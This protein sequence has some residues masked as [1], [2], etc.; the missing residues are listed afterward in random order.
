[1]ATV[2]LARTVAGP[3]DGFPVLL[4]H[5]S[6]TDR[7]VWAPQIAELA[8]AGYR[9]IAADLRGHGESPLGE[10][11]STPETMA[12]DVFALLDELGIARFVVGGFSYGGWVAMEILRQS[13][14]RV[15]GL[16]LISTGAQADTAKEKA[17]R[18]T[19]AQ[20]IRRD[21]LNPDGYRERVLTPETLRTRPDAWE[22]ARETMAAVSV[23]GRARAVEGMAARRDFRPLLPSVRVP[24]LVIVGA[25]DPITP[26]ALAKEIHRLVPGSFLQEV[27]GASHLVTLEAPG[28]VSQAILN[29]LA[30]SG[31]APE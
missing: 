27:E 22:G 15:A 24:T 26:P 17:M 23:E 4:L 16:L 8:S 20:A 11:P 7:R 12:V 30:F 5:G 6:P 25:D 29:W 19:Q 3:P 31:F 18:P 21:G 1:M 2:K 14:Q 13:P 9:V 28:I 10:R